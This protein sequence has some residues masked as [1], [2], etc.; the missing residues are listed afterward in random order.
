MA[1][2]RKTLQ[3]TRLDARSR[4]RP[5]KLRNEGKSKRR[6]RSRCHY[7]R[8]FGY[9]NNGTAHAQD[10]TNSDGLAP[11]IRGESQTNYIC[12]PGQPQRRLHHA[13]QQF[14][15][16]VWELCLQIPALPTKSP[17]HRNPDKGSPLLG[18]IRT[19]EG[20]TIKADAV[21]CIPIYTRRLWHDSPDVP[22]HVQ[23]DMLASASM[24]AI[25]P[26]HESSRKLRKTQVPQ[27]NT[28]L[29]IHKTRVERGLECTSAST[30][31]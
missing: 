22:S 13:H 2:V 3:P 17:P 30:F 8:P 20:A 26:L 23:L 21:T 25:A 15:P 5:H 14:P 18:A 12:F 7:F 11:T 29:L 27:L 16:A 6:R 28:Q 19:P 4:R 24:L 31:A 10:K 9:Q 1:S